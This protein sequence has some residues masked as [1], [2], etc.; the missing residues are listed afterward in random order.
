MVSFYSLFAV[1]ECFVSSVHIIFIAPEFQPMFLVLPAITIQR[2]VGKSFNKVGK[3][4]NKVAIIKRATIR[5][6]IT[7]I[8]EGLSSAFDNVSFILKHGGLYS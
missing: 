7:I 3:S 5:L 8:F 4:F 2:W 6:I 1:Q